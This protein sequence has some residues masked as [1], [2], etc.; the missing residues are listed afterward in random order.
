MFFGKTQL[1][2]LR[3]RIPLIRIL[4]IQSWKFLKSTFPLA[5]KCLTN[6]NIPV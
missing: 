2:I 4:G 6:K 1:D 3:K 5:G